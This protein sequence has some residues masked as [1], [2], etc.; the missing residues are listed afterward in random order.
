MVALLLKKQHG[1]TIS[2]GYFWLELGTEEVIKCCSTQPTIWNPN[3]K[4]AK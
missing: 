4:T 3:Q 2:G 1:L